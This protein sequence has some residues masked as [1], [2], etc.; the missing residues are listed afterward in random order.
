MWFLKEKSATYLD[1]KQHTSFPYLL[2]MFQAHDEWQRHEHSCL[3]DTQAWISNL[4]PEI[5]NFTFVSGLC[6]IWNISGVSTLQKQVNIKV[7]ELKLEYK[8]KLW[9]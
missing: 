1:V 5:F 2:G 3:E 6:K 7:D 9:Y 8:A 4:K